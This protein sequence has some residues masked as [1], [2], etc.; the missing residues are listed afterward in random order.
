[1]KAPLG[2]FFTKNPH[3]SFIRDI[4]VSKTNYNIP[5]TTQSTL[6]PISEHGPYYICGE[7]NPHGNGKMTPCSHYLHPATIN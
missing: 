5:M 4:R 7:E 6:K 1:M 2:A 3:N